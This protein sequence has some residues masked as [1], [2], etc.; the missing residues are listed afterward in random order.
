MIVWLFAIGIIVSVA[1]N[2]GASI[3]HSEALILIGLTI[4]GGAIHLKRK[5]RGRK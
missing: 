5:M 1:F 3:S 2:T 4:I